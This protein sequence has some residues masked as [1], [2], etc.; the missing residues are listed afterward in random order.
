LPEDLLNADVEEVIKFEADGPVYD[1]VNVCDS[2]SQAFYRCVE[3][4]RL[5]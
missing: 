4:K 3:E 1:F 5:E 2:N